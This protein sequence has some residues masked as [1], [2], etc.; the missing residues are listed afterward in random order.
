MDRDREGIV[1]G[2]V[3]RRRRYSADVDFVGRCMATGFTR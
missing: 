1:R 2:E 3:I